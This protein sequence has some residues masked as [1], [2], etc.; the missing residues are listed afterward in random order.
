L[1]RHAQV[2]RHDMLIGEE[3]KDYTRS[4]VQFIVDAKLSFNTVENMAFKSFVRTLNK[5]APTISRTTLSRIITE[6]HRERKPMILEV[7]KNIEGNIAITCDG[8]SSRI[9][10]GF[11]A[12]TAHWITAEFELKNVLIDFVYFPAPHNQWTTKAVLLSVLH[13]FGIE[14]KVTAVTTDSG[15]E[16]PK[17]MEHVRVDLNSK[18]NLNIPKYWHVRCAC[19]V[20]HR[21]VTDAIE[22]LSATIQLLRNLLS[23]I[24]VSQ[25]NRSLFKDAQKHL[26]HSKIR[27][28]PTNDIENRWSSTFKMVQKAYDLKWV[29]EIVCNDER[30]TDA[31]RGK[32]LKDESWNNLKAVAEFL[33]LPAEITEISSSSSN[34]TISIQYKIFHLLEKHCTDH[35]ASSSG[36]KVVKSAAAK[37]KVKLLKYKPSLTSDYVK[38]CAALDPR[39]SKK[40]EDHTEIK[41]TLRKYLTEKYGASVTT[42]SQPRNEA[43]E[44]FSIFD[45]E[46]DS[47]E[48]QNS[49][50][51]DK[52]FAATLR[53][54]KSC[55]FR[56][57]VTSYV[58]IAHLF[59]MSVFVSLLL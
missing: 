12:V 17:A 38:M 35:L 9:F 27:D 42:S 29:F 36:L 21:A 15:P 25:H 2:R 51:I 4:L 16:M 14:K 43:K 26:D 32:N 5:H 57:V 33:K 37:L 40:N 20:I 13:E 8:W 41:N 19:H 58:Q 30:A 55:N 1:S 22:P 59:Q 31:I 47:D 28:V 7:L 56:T 52:F 49:D 53:A 6:E 39:I 45:I 48:D 11:F 46:S 44:Q 54:D 50:E 34:A 10:R 18:Y 23:G 24:R 3:L